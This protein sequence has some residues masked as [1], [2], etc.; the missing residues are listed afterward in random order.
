MGLGSD[1]CMS[2]RGE[3]VCAASDEANALPAYICPASPLPSSLL[4]AASNASKQQQVP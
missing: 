4:D 3:D 1:S 2:L